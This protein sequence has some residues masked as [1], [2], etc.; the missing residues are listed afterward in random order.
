M[1]KELKNIEQQLK[2]QTEMKTTVIINILL[3]YLFLFAGSLNMINAQDNTD[4]LKLE[5]I[6]AESG[7]D[8]TRVMSRAGYTLIV[9]DQSGP[10]G[11]VVNRLSVNLGVN[12]WS[13]SGKYEA[14][15]VAPSNP[16]DGFRAGFGDMK[17][18]VLNAFYVKGNSALAGSVEFSLPT[19]KPGIGS[20]YFSATPS[21][22]FSYTINPTLFIAV[23][24]QYTF[25]LMK[26]PL[27]PDLSVL[28]VRTFLAKFTKN[29]YFFV[30]EPRPV[31]NFGND[32]IDFIIAPIIGKALGGGFNFIAL[33]EF[34]TKSS[35]YF[36]RGA[37]YQFGFNKS[38]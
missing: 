32:E 29:G 13:F 37:L 2:M 35:T 23:Q 14:V 38:F 17:F 11:Q 18:S 20:Q 30:F 6:R 31:L 16:G 22:T 21:L 1:K 4:S 3:T 15:M 26:D 28:T 27:Y 5:K 34:P 36:S 24:P 19:G 9:Y 7:V 10:A 25:D 33:A 8:P 12:R